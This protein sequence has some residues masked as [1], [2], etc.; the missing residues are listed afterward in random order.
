MHQEQRNIGLDVVRAAAIGLVLFAHWSEAIARWYGLHWRSTAAVIA[1]FWGVELFFAL[2][3]FLIGRLLL[4]LVERD[5]SRRGWWRF[6]VRRWMRTL[7]L[8]FACL[9]GLAILWPP[10]TR[11]F[12]HLLQ[13]GFFT[14]NLLGPMP[15]DYWFV[16]SW[17]LSIEEWFY[18]LFSA[19][20]VGGY[21]LAG[22]KKWWPGACIALFIII[23]IFLRWQLVGPPQSGGQIHDVV[24]LR[25]D[26]IAYGAAIGAV[27]RGRNT[28]TAISALLAATGLIMLVEQWF[29]PL[30][31]AW[32]PYRAF[33]V[34]FFTVP[35]L[36]F[37]LCLPAASRIRRLPKPVAWTVRQVSVQSYAL[38]LTHFALLSSVSAAQ[39]RFAL[40]GST[41]VSLSV[42]LI[43]GVSYAL[44]HWLEAP[45]M[46]LRP[47]QYPAVGEP[48]TAGL[49]PGETA[50]AQTGFLERVRARL[51]GRAQSLALARPASAPDTMGA[52]TGT[53]SN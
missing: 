48:Q 18:L 25:L 49:A 47:K 28:A 44:H 29:Q 24:P 4:E 26:A 14:Q 10:E 34:L 21:A 7:P 23:P 17:S 53:P 45:I 42:V 36:A 20:L 9:V 12:S 16:S 35:A 19:L 50:V 52:A 30:S 41:C 33:Q 39:N 22:R 15:S 37:A 6:M 46:N 40:N 13:Y 1:G 27:F 11:P 5:P 31:L 43:F 8:Y 38:Y 32:M 2:S 3:G 51:S